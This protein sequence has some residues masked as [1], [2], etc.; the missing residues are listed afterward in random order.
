M[1]TDLPYKS[2]KAFNITTSNLKNLKSIVCATTRNK[3]II[4][5]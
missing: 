1:T 5:K 4:D 2:P 3:M